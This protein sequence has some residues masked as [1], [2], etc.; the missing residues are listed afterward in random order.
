MKGLARWCFKHRKVVLLVWLL[1]LV[2]FFDASRLAGTSFSTKFS[3]PN[4]PS[5]TALNLLQ[6]DFPAASGS[7]D[8]I[9]LHATSG[10][11]RDAPVEARAQRMLAAVATL[12]HV[13]S[14]VSPFSTQGSGQ[15][16]KDGTVAFAT[17]NFNEQSQNLSK[18][19]VQRVITSAQ[20]AGDQRL[21]VA[22]GGPDV[23]NAERQ[24]PSR[25]TGLGVVFALIVLG[26]AFGALFAAVLPLITALIAIGVGYSITGLLTHVFSISSFATILGI[27]IGL[28]VG[29]DYALLIVTRHRA[30]LRGGRSVEESAVNSLNTAGRAVLFAGIT[31]CIAL[32]GQFALG[33]SFLYGVAVSAAITVALTMLASLTLL[34]ALLGFLGPKVLSRRQRARLRVT[35][36][37]AEEVAGFWY[38]WAKG[39]ERRPVLPAV[40][41]LA[42][43]VVI[44]LPIFSLRLGLDDA[45]SDPAGT[46]SHQAYEL[47]AEGFGPGFN[48]PLELVAELPHP[49]D[50]ARFVSLVHALARQPGVVAVTPS[51][52]S[53][54]RTVAI[55]QVYPST[56]PQ[57]V[58]T[59]ALVARLRNRVIPAAE[60]GTGLR[61]YVG[62]FT[63][64]QVDF[65]H[66]LSSKLFLFV[67]VVIVLGFLLLMALFRSLLIPLI[68]SVM[69]L[70]SV[71]AALGI[72]NA[73]FEWGWG[74]SLFAISTIAPVEV[75]VP[76]IMISILFGLSMDYEV[77]LVSRMHEEWLLKRDNNLAV[78]LGQ[79][80]TGRVITA[81]A[82]I[83]ILVFVS[84]VFGDDIV[85]KQFGIGLA[86]AIIIDAFIVRTAL[87]PSL[88][89]LFGK[90]NWWLP[91]W[92]DRIVP[93][94]HV[95]AADLLASPAAERV[96]ADSVLT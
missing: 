33:V 21:A 12:P 49:A 19:A 73:I 31:V 16:S 40:L 54:N 72:M 51:I 18:A 42:A 56:S 78:T 30:G 22:V 45:G 74:R 85:I 88:M 10:T 34:P 8:Q 59:S 44:A 66:V 41:A 48:G 4:T 53:P 24:S 87:V 92:L 36:P 89:H 57:S 1:A 84:F 3:L 32:L 38:R 76:V 82:A 52:V 77:F 94:L 71:G 67:G 64:G 70:L 58:K 95:E 60:V 28:G 68:A 23:E 14:V 47:L 83:M 35:G 96:P 15:I 63:A 46:T 20:A 90:A 39:I 61:V 86:G 6:K 25:S 75:F 65:A 9:V 11:V 7:S 93:Q 55:A 81:A 27:L 17:V 26:L 13:R 79:A 43:V 5:A 91:A 69:N 29:V 37:V 80:E 62:G 2:G 50:E